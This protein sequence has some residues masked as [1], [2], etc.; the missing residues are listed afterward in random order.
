MRVPD[1]NADQDWYSS[2]C[3]PEDPSRDLESAWEISPADIA[4]GT[5]VSDTLCPLYDSD[6]WKLVVTGER[7]LVDVQAT[8]NKSGNIQLAIDWFGPRGL[9]VPTS[10]QSCSASSE[11]GASF[12]D[13]ARGG[14]R[15][16]N[17]PLCFGPANCP[18]E[19]CAVAEN[20]AL[21][22]PILEIPGGG[23]QHRIA[24]IF[25][26]FREGTYALRIYDRISTVEDATTEY[27]LTV[28]TRQDTD[29]NEPNDAPLL[30]TPLTDGTPV[31]GTFSYV[32]D[33]DWFRITPGFAGTAVVYVELFYPDG[34]PAVPAFRVSQGGQVF[35]AVGPPSTPRAAVVD[36]VTGRLWA[37]ARVLGS[38][39]PIDVEVWNT[40]PSV[41][42]PNHAYTLTVRV[43]Q[44]ADEPTRDDR[45]DAPR[46]VSIGAPGSGTQ[47]VTQ[48]LVA[49]NDYDWYSL[50]KTGSSWS[51]LDLRLAAN[52]TPAP[53]LLQVQAYYPR[54]TTCTETTQCQDELLTGKPEIC[55]TDVGRCYLWFQRPK[56]ELPE[57]A[58]TS[59]AYEFGG[60]EPERNNLHTQ[61]PIPPASEG[62]VLLQVKHIEGTPSGQ[63]GYSTSATYTLTLNHKVEPDPGDLNTPDNHIVTRPLVGEDGVGY[64]SFHRAD[65]SMTNDTTLTGGARSNESFAVLTSSPAL[66]VG[67][68]TQLA[69]A[70]YDDLAQTLGAGTV[71]ITA[72][73][74]QLF[75][76]A[77]C[78]TAPA[79]NSYALPGEAPYIR[80]DAAGAGTIVASMGTPIT[81]H[82]L[83]YTGT[84]PV[85]LGVPAPQDG[86]LNAVLGAFDI[87]VPSAPSANLVLGMA[88]SVGN[89]EITCG[90]QFGNPPA[91][92][93]ENGLTSPCPETNGPASCQLQIMAGQTSQSFYILSGGAS[94]G[95]TVLTISPPAGNTAYIPA[96]FVVT[97]REPLLLTYNRN[98]TA[99]GWISYEG[100]AD[101]FTV[102]VPSLSGVAAGTM[103]A[104]LH[105]KGAIN[106]RVGIARQSSSNSWCTGSCG[107]II[108][109]CNA[110]CTITGGSS[111]Y[112]V[113]SSGTYFNVWV[114]DINHD[115]WDD[116]Q[117]YEISWTFEEGCADYC[118]PFACN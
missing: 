24:T 9:C 38:A 50:T 30:A 66:A 70:L 44:D 5:P 69:F 26:A 86:N 11:C 105:V 18:G 65:R 45:A 84:A 85:P 2:A 41:L 117:Y 104:T 111:C 32:N 97:P 47:T 7:Q 99:R 107:I 39:E 108:E 15:A 4:A 8:Y 17:A 60:C 58:P 96:T 78:T 43:L 61:I 112:Y 100:D 89:G 42:A 1:V 118:H 79:D 98:N 74:A 48:R 71:T 36:T 23:S 21:Q 92:Q 94:P 28:T 93:E 57:N 106:A 77:A 95:L 22:G 29:V 101:F 80:A 114:N 55:L 25:P 115:D 109:D 75:T 10:P 13:P 31:S 88:I 53:F 110:P 54:T 52:A 34:M 72:T 76:D 12:C 40:T 116:G 87:T 37:S 14:C 63:L 67:A 102:Q 91:C 82:T 35:T 59:C 6:F 81:F 83:A 20:D 113:T 103:T 33:V 19:T 73:G 68:C 64:S 3:L 27:Q 46:V 49:E 56:I 51:L 90:N 62:P 16:P